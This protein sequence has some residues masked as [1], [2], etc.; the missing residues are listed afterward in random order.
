MDI[1]TIGHSSHSQDFFDKMLKKAGIELLADV[2]AFP[3][4]RKWP[5]FSKDEFPVWLEAEGI[6]YEHFSKLG[7]RRRKSKEVEEDRNA[8]WRNQSFHNYADYTLTEEFQQ[9]ITE[10]LEKASVKRVAYCC[11]ERHPSRCHRLLIS[12]YL[13]A[14]GHRVF[15]I[16][17]GKKGAVDIVEHEVGM[18]GAEAV[19]NDK[20]VVTYPPTG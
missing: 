19:V 5:Q 17:D 9:G 13:A 20:G 4:S 1:Y 3:G 8:G 12:N 6:G 11:S 14:N 16:I 7:G 2:R 18:W 10:L 15:H